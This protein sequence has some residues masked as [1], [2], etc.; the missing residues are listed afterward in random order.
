MPGS[1]PLSI[2]PR[3]QQIGG[4]EGHRTP[5]RTRM[6]GLLCQ[7]SYVT[8]ADRPGFEPS[9]FSFGDLEGAR[10]DLLKPTIHYQIWVERWG[11]NPRQPEPQSG[12]LPTELLSTL[13]LVDPG[14]LE[15]PTLC[16]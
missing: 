12:A 16:L 9:L 2:H 10:H 5:D 15:P 14:G 6:K 13:N 3:V 8:L 11:S 1:R 4:N 7:L